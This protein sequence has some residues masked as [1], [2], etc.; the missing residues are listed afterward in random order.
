MASNTSVFCLD[1]GRFTYLVCL[2]RRGSDQVSLNSSHSSD[3]EYAIYAYRTM[4]GVVTE[5][6][7]LFTGLGTASN[8]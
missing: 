1:C 4:L 6:H 2:C 5:P 7:V 8:W 3:E